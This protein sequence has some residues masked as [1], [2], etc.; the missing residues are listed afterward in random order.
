[1]SQTQGFGG[2]VQNW[3]EDGRLY[4]WGGTISAIISWVLVPLF[5]LFAMYSGYRLYDDQGKALSSALIAGFGG[6]GFFAWI[7]YLATL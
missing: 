1:M 5:G 6:I 3:K 7:F 2:T 4:L